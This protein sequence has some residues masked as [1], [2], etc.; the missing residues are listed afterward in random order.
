MWITL[1]CSTGGFISCKFNI[2]LDLFSHDIGTECI[3]AE[4]WLLNTF[5]AVLGCRVV[6]FVRCNTAVKTP[7][8]NFISL[9]LKCQI[10]CMHTLVVD[11]FKH[12][13]CVFM[14][15]SRLQCSIVELRVGW[16]VSV[17][18]ICWLNKSE[19]FSVFFIRPLRENSGWISPMALTS[20][21]HLRQ[22]M[23]ANVR[24]PASGHCK[25]SVIIIVVF[26]QMWFLLFF[27][28]F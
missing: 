22:S 3:S 23:A 21:N 17:G 25:C 2:L 12:Y 11:I 8:W 16:V 26:V 10:V 20:T 28:L 5:A 6:Y 19:A 24:A 7:R 9:K 18:G 4:M 27:S 14:F 13:V 15:S 1:K